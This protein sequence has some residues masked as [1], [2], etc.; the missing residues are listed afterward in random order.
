MERIGR[1][2]SKTDVEKSIKQK[3]NYKK[4]QV[5]KVTKPMCINSIAKR[6]K[7]RG[8]ERK[9]KKKKSPLKSFA[10][11]FT[12]KF[13]S[14]AE[15][16]SRGCQLGKCSRPRAPRQVQF[17]PLSPPPPSPASCLCYSK[18][19]E[20]KEN[21][22]R[23]TAWGGGSSS[24]PALPLFR[25]ES[26]LEEFFSDRSYLDSYLLPGGDEVRLKIFFI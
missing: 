11:H 19:R 18:R 22:R 26:R 24:R 7:R 2:R 9:R 3:L 12:G 17:L 20:W 5:V 16:M 21:T 4:S 23:R 6:K 25:P 8:E 1:G 15:L 10:T 13:T 14:S